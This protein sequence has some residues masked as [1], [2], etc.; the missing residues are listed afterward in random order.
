MVVMLPP[1]AELAIVLSYWCVNCRRMDVVV[2]EMVQVL[3][4]G[5]AEVEVRWQVVQADRIGRSMSTDADQQSH[6]SEGQALL[7]LRPFASYEKLDWER[8]PS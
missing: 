6:L 2:M 4:D 7:C 3:M 8:L 1:Q 5:P